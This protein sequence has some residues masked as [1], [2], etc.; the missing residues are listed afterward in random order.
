M[1]V[2]TQPPPARLHAIACI[3]VGIVIDGFEVL[4]H[5]GLEFVKA[6]WGCLFAGVIAVPV[7]PPDPTR[8]AQTLPGLVRIVADCGAKAMLTDWQ[9]DKVGTSACVLLV[10]RPHIASHAGAVPNITGGVRWL[11]SV[12]WVGLT[13]ASFE[14]APSTDTM[15]C[16][17]SW[18]HISLLSGTQG[19]V[20]QVQRMQHLCWVTGIC[21]TTR[22]T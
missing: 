5:A 14:W 13:A 6:M 21:C 16:Q 18:T 8:I 20:L 12:R 22:Q 17:D 2:H 9:Y 19:G 10:T 11:L 1:G 15:H 3:P 7:C 4:L